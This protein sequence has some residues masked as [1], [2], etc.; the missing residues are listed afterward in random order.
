MC[1][2]EKQDK[3][4]REFRKRQTRESWVY[5]DW[6]TGMSFF[7]SPSLNSLDLSG[8]IFLTSEMEQTAEKVYTRM[9]H[10]LMKSQ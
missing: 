3:A 8:S 10:E 6:V 4:Y 9:P 2:K 5:M 1:V 7:E